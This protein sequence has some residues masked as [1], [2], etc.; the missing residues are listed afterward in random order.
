MPKQINHHGFLITVLDN[1]KWYINAK[2]MTDKRGGAREGAGRK[3]G[4]ETVVKTYRC[5]PEEVPAI[6]AAIK[7]EITKLRKSK[8]KPPP[9]D[10]A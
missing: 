5:Y 2:G 9:N 3:Q 4:K 10:Y 1:G 6:K 8:P 7:K